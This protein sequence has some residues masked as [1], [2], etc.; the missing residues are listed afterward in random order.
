[1]FI[2]ILKSSQCATTVLKLIF[3]ITVAVCE[4]RNDP[5]GVTVAACE[6]RNDPLS[7]TVAVC[8][9]CSKCSN[10]FHFRIIVFLILN[11]PKREAGRPV[12]AVRRIHVTTVKV[13]GVRKGS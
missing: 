13:Q 6:S 7:A 11:A 10:T 4:S 1:L 3:N 8:D 9:G 2:C 5:L 12:K